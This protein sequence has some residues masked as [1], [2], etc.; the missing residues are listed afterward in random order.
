ME[1]MNTAAPRPVRKPR[2]APPLEVPAVRARPNATEN[3]A[4]HWPASHHHP[5]VFAYAAAVSTQPRRAWVEDVGRTGL[6]CLM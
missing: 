5:K 6:S 4:S 3:P 1:K 2:A